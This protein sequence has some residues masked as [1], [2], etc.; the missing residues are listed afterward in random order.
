LGVAP[1]GNLVA[2]G[3]IAPHE[4]LGQVFDDP[5]AVVLVFQRVGPS[6][7]AALRPLAM[8]LLGFA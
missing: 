1:R 6:P 7:L 5:W 3:G 8:G 2:D 4:D